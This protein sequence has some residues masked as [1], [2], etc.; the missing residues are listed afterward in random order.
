MKSK[1]FLGLILLIIVIVIVGTLDASAMQK[2]VPPQIE[3]YGI[4]NPVGY[5]PD[6][7]TEPA[8]AVSCGV[9]CYSIS[10]DAT[11]NQWELSCIPAWFLE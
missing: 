7:G 3:T 6:C 10:E 11:A 5:T 9:M 8:N 4:P 2:P 1:L